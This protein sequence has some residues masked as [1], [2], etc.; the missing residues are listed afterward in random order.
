M[1]A[2]VL[3]RFAGQLS[4]EP[5]GVAAQSKP[6]MISAAYPTPLKKG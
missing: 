3:L 2:I 6:A 4:I 5:S 1:S